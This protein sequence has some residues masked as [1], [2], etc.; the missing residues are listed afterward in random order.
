M[1]LLVGNKIRIIIGLYDF[2]SPF[3]LYIIGHEKLSEILKQKQEVHCYTGG[4]SERVARICDNTCQLAG[5]YC[6]D[7]T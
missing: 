1:G 7:G 4:W 5:E 3:Q 2:H 6:E